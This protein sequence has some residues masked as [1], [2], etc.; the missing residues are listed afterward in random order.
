MTFSV[1]NS[2]SDKRINSE[3]EFMSDNIISTNISISSSDVEEESRL[4][5]IIDRDL[6]IKG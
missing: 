1:F 5:M 6:K 3:F 2:D 4:A